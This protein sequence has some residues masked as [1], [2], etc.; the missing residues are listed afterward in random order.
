[1]VPLEQ[2][3]GIRAWYMLGTSN[4]QDALERA[5]VDE[6][7]GDL[8]IITYKNEVLR[9]YADSFKI[10][11]ANNLVVILAGGKHYTLASSLQVS[12]R[13]NEIME[14]WWL[15]SKNTYIQE[16][17]ELKNILDCIKRGETWRGDIFIKGSI[18]SRALTFAR[19]TMIVPLNE[20][21][22]IGFAN[23]GRKYLIQGPR[24]HQFVANTIHVNGTSKPKLHAVIAAM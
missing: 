9:F 12:P 24:E 11:S 15:E 14:R 16:S 23:D 7:S 10:D 8:T 22:R 20:N 4:Y 19:L 1:M 13:N 17:P 6:L 2:K 5:S 3:T 18:S 21:L